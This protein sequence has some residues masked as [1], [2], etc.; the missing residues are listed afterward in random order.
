MRRHHHT[1]EGDDFAGGIHD[2]T[3][4]RNRS[5][6]WVGG[7]RH[8]HNHHLVLLAHLLTDADELVRLHRQ[9]AEPNVGWVYAQVLQLKNSFEEIKVRTFS[10]IMLPHFTVVE[11]HITV[12]KLVSSWKQIQVH[13]QEMAKQFIKMTTQMQSHLKKEYDHRH[14]FTYTQKQKG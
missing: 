10:L 13:F 11:Y 7:I 12:S 1:F 2:G 3:V 14:V 4:G 6:D 9:I 5:P 8:V